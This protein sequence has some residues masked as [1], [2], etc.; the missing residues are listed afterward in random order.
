MLS[1]IKLFH[2]ALLDISS[3]NGEAYVIGD[4]VWLRH[5]LDDTRELIDVQYRSESRTPEEKEVKRR[6]KLHYGVV[7]HRDISTYDEM[8]Y[9]SAAAFVAAASRRPVPRGIVEQEV[10]EEPVGSKRKEPPSFFE[11]ILESMKQRRQHEAQVA[12]VQLKNS[13]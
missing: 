11:E 4:R 6:F 7:V 3:G 5:L 13:K 2:K 8:F 10:A 9:I 1:R 12:A